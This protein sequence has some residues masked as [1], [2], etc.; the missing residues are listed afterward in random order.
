[1]TPGHL[2]S[3][4]GQHDQTRCESKGQWWEH[5]STRRTAVAVSH[6]SER[7]VLDKEELQAELFSQ[8]RGLFD[9]EDQV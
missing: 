2:Q 7:G 4:H 9:N 3:L 8:F 5:G 6:P 1:M